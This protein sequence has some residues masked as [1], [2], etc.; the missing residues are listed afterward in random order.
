MVQ[1]QSTEV[2]ES[3]AEVRVLEEKG[4]RVEHE[5]GAMPGK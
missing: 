4:K 2:S 5:L 1:R 3:T